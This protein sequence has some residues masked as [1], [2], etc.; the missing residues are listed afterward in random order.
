MD[1]SITLVRK[2]NGS[3]RLCFDPKDFNKNIERKQY[4]PRTIDD[5]SLE[6]HGSRYVTMMDPSQATGWSDW[7]ERAHC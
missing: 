4:Y 1:H 5:L 6:F 7:T 3:Q 2:A